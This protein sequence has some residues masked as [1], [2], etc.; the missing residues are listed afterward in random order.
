M[1]QVRAPARP[2]AERTSPPPSQLRRVALP[3]RCAQGELEQAAAAQLVDQLLIDALGFG[4]AR[5]G[6]E[7][8]QRGLD[9]ARQHVVQVL[10][11]SAA[12]L[13]IAALERAARQPEGLAIEDQPE[14]A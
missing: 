13:E 12:Q 8:K 6:D 3:L 2:R 10:E 9:R 5:I 7:L 11:R 4:A 1:A 14:Q